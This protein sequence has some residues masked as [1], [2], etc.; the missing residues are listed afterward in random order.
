MVASY[1][2][3]VLDPFAARLT[4]MVS[5]NSLVW[6]PLVWTQFVDK[7]FV[8]VVPVSKRALAIRP[9][10]LKGVIILLFIPV[11]A[12]FLSSIHQQKI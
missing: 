4:G 3:V 2:A 6:I 5:F 11:A 1:L 9:F 7:R 10:I 12:L 8:P